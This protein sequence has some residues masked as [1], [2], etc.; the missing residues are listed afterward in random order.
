MF[1]PEHAGLASQLALVF[2]VGCL[3]VVDQ[4]AHKHAITNL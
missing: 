4:P 1:A 3:D 2:E